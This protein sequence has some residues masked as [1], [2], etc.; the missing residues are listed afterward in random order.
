MSSAEASPTLV[1]PS[2]SMNISLQIQ[3]V[4][5][6]NSSYPSLQLIHIAPE[7]KGGLGNCSIRLFFERLGSRLTRGW[8]MSPK[9]GICLKAQN[10]HFSVASL[11]Q[12]L[13]FTSNW[14]GIPSIASP[15]LKPCW[16]LCLFLF[17]VDF[18]KVQKDA[19]EEW[20]RPTLLEA[21]YEGIFQALLGRKDVTQNMTKRSCL[22]PGLDSTKGL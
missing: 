22:N 2:F 17:F 20:F 13:T 12:F 14:L 3:E 18:D 11:H 21:G 8:C 16:L 9:E 10:H 19:F 7:E 5:R 4:T 6:L 1:L 15:T